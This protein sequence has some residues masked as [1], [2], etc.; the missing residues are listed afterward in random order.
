MPPAQVCTN[1]IMIDSTKWDVV[2]VMFFF[3]LR[4]DGQIEIYR[5]ITKANLLQRDKQINVKDWQ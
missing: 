5:Q 2:C 3:N 4:K 1:Y